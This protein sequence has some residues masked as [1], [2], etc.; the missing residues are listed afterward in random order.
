MLQPGSGTPTPVAVQFIGISPSPSPSGQGIG[1]RQTSQEAE[2]AKDPPAQPCEPTGG[3]ENAAA[4]TPQS[5]GEQDQ[6]AQPREPASGIEE[7]EVVA[8]TPR[9]E[10]EQDLSHQAGA[11]AASKHQAAEEPESCAAAC[12]PQGVRLGPGGGSNEQ[13][14]LQG[15][16]GMG[17]P[18]RRE[19]PPGC[20]GGGVLPPPGLA[21]PQCLSPPSVLA[22]VPP[23]W[24][25]TGTVSETTVTMQP[26]PL[27]MS[28]VATTGR[29]AQVTPG[30]QAARS[31]VQPGWL[32]V[33]LDGELYQEP[34]LHSKIAGG[35]PYNTTFSVQEGVIPALLVA[36][37][38]QSE[39]QSQR[40]GAV[41]QDVREPA[42]SPT[43]APDSWPNG[44]PG[45]GVGGQGGD[46]GSP[47]PFETPAKLFSIDDN[48]I[49]VNGQRF[50]AADV[51]ARLQQLQ[52]QDSV[53]D[54]APS[55][56]AQQARA[57]SV[58]GC[59]RRQ[60]GAQVLAEVTCSLSAPACD[61]LPETRW[62]DG[63]RF[64][65]GGWRRRCGG[66]LLTGATLRVALRVDACGPEVIL[67]CV[68][69][70]WLLFAGSAAL[71]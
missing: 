29:V 64:G 37:A 46:D 67:A 55:P 16:V 66:G 21:Q 70:C 15:G 3:T 38:A 4:G 42:R 12:A 7:W 11:A 25:S 47:L 6:R 20:R 51:V 18:C 69:L 1:S 57:S 56:E 13:N 61:L 14:A 71:T 40:W 60:D 68:C 17:G 22:G 53:G 50:L 10:E 26:G 28:M 35:R 41:P 34:L 45:A 62:F 49:K 39:L 9:S 8:A 48:A 2:P 65:E 23:G 24:P 19:Q 5:T 58:D 52:A 63:R 36:R 54:Q 59:E 43:A 30:G 31:G 33:S 27:H 32:L 44:A